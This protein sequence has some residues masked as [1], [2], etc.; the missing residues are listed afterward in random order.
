MSS[1][2]YENEPGYE[3]RQ[4]PTDK[5]AQRNY[6]Q[7]VCN[8]FKPHCLDESNFHL[9][10]RHEALRISVIQRLESYLALHPSGRSLVIAR[11]ELSSED[12]EDEELCPFEPFKDLCKRRFLWYFE[13]YLSNVEQ[14]M[15]DFKDGTL[16]VRMPF[17]GSSNTMDGKFVYGELRTRLLK[18]KTT[19][20]AETEGWAQEGLL[21]REKESTVAVNLQHQFHQA[22]AAFKRNDLPH[23]LSLDNGNPFLWTMTYFGQPMTNFD[24]G[25]LRV[26]MHFSPRFPDEQPRIVFENKIF[27]HHVTSDGTVCYSPRLTKREDVRSHLEAIIAVLEVEEPAYDPRETVNLEATKL[28]W[29]KVEDGR[30]KYNR[31]LRR[32]VQQSME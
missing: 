17:E 4:G 23:D 24:G 13:S 6:V 20:D 30:K 15:R 8:R 1:N 28:Y 14:G 26:K 22:V 27:H 12:E 25:I 7:K 21:A 19:I 9:Q 11:V 2:P 32:S 29:G 3:T 31:N 5:I 10:I 18:I 16:F